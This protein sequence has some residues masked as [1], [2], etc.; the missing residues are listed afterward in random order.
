MI[1]IQTGDITKI[2]N[3]QYICNAANGRGP[4][5]AGVAGAIRR[6]GGMDIQTEAMQICT[7]FDVEPGDIY[8]T[9]AGTLPYDGVIHLCTMKNPGSPSN[10]N[11]IKNCLDSL[12]Q[13]CNEEEIKTVAIPALGTGIGGVNKVQ[14]AELY[15]NILNKATTEFIVTDIDADFI[16]Y[17]NM[18]LSMR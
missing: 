11:I 3:V 17:V 1:K 12:I 18:Y 7:N 2:E 5:G 15:V 14:V 8:I 10:I 9:K 6:A 13:F 4:M 16:A